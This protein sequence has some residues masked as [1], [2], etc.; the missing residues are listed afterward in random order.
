[1]ATVTVMCF[2]TGCQDAAPVASK[3]STPPAEALLTLLYPPILLENGVRVATQDC[4]RRRGFAY[5]RRLLQDDESI[6]PPTLVGR[7]LTVEAARTTGYGFTTRPESPSL[8]R[9]RPSS[10]MS[11]PID[12]ALDPGRPLVKVRAGDWLVSATAVGCISEG[13]QAVYGSVR[14]YLILSY[15]PQAIRRDLFGGFDSIMRNSDV[16][17]SLSGYTACMARFGYV[18]RNPSQARRIAE[19]LFGQLQGRAG[20]VERRMALRDAR[21]QRPWRP[22]ETVSDALFQSGADILRAHASDVRSL[23]TILLASVE[24]ARSILEESQG[25]QS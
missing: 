14:D 15:E 5:H 11:S 23:H 19:K 17:A 22:Y 10:R 7:P 4:M 1:M 3:S 20:I 24:R 16:R 13:R 6:A 21:C 25:S 8:Q 12:D 2:V 18:V 9:T